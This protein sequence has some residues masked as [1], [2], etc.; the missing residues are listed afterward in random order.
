[1]NFESLL[2]PID[3]ENPSGVEL[4]HDLRFHDLERLTEPAAR[5]FRITEDGTL[6]DAAPDVD[7]HR[8][9]GDGEELATDGRDLRL[10]VLMSRAFYNV[11]GF[12]GLAAALGF[13]TR[14][15][16]QYWQSLHPALRDRDEPQMAA[17]PRLNALRQ[18]E[19]D[20]NGLLGDLRFGVVLNPR[21]IGPITGDDL[22]AA[23]LSEFEMLSRAASGLS[24]AERDAL[25]SAHGQRVNRVQAATRGLAAE[26]AEAMKALIEAIKSCESGLVDIARA[27]ADAGN[28]GDAPGLSMAEIEEVLN[29]CRKTLEAAVAATVKDAPAVVD[30]PTVAV[31]TK[32]PVGNHTSQA[33]PGTIASRGD[34]ETSLDRIIA[35]YERT[36][37]S[38]PIP[39]LARRMRRMVAMDFLELMEE[40]APSGLKEFRSVAGVEDAKKK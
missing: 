30:D 37:P 28:F 1:M 10:L 20:D 18:L 16:T 6:G 19:N 15:V 14:T 32:A 2:A 13:L 11:E 24:Q 38:S 17:L 21:G 12:A 36:E 35:F 3:G 27:V 33:A 22:V 25:V 7:W 9:I 34:V 8:I 31:T 29:L 4:R 40:I 39:H 5:E 26:D 23:S